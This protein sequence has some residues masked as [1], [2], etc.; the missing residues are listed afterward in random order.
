[1]IGSFELPRGIGRVYFALLALTVVMSTASRSIAQPDLNWELRI[2]EKEMQ[3][4]HTGDQAWVD[5]LAYDNGF[6][7][8]WHRNMPTLELSNTS[9]A[10]SPAIDKFELTIGD[11]RFHFT[12]DHFGEFAHL[13]SS[14]PGFVLNSSVSDG[15]NRLIVD[16]DKLD[17]TDLA[18]DEVVRFQI[19]LGVDAGFDFFSYPD[20][21]TVLFDMNGCNVYDNNTGCGSPNAA[22]NAQGS[23]IFADGTEVGPQAFADETVTG[24]SSMYF[25]NIFPRHSTSQTVDIFEIGGTSV[26]PEPSSALLALFSILAGMLLPG[27]QRRQT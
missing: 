15:G 13:G 5:A 7:R 1:M 2:S 14:T 9:G 24:N 8:M 19:Q 3:L 27:R 22:D 11:T 4:E 6:T 10:G 17:G 23:V 21:R 18:V 12:D 25:N 16:I 26:I 20:F